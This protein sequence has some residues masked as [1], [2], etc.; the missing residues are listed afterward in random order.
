MTPQEQASRLLE[1]W[2]LMREL[3]PRERVQKLELAE[4]TEVID[5]VAREMA[6]AA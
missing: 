5:R 2:Q 6:D 1:L 3:E 4:Y